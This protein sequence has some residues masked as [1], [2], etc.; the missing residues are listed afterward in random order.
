MESRY[1]QDITK[2]RCEGLAVECERKVLRARLGQAKVGTLEN[3]IQM[4]K[5]V[6]YC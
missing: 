1:F 3:F 6:F 5:Y 2:R 4:H